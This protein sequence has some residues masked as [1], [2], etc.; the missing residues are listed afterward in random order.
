MVDRV[1]ATIR[2]RAGLFARPAATAGRTAVEALP[3][4]A[5]PWEQSGTH[6]SDPLIEADSAPPP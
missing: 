6:A 5:V 2:W 4:P 3:K 1:E